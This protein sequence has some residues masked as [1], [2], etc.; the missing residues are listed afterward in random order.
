M[1]PDMRVASPLLP[2]SQAGHAGGVQQGGAAMLGRVEGGLRQRNLLIDLEAGD[3]FSG[4]VLL[5]QTSAYQPESRMQ[6]GVDWLSNI[7]NPR[8]FIATSRNLPP[9]W[10]INSS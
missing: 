1:L 7:R 9:E 8:S 2:R 10:V 4:G 6:A 5:H 3:I